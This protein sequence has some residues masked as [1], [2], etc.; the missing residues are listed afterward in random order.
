MVERKPEFQFSRSPSKVKEENGRN[1]SSEA[2]VINYEEDGKKFTALYYNTS[3]DPRN[4]PEVGDKV[5]ND[6]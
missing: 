3:C 1:R 2:G 5:Q 4:C 6:S